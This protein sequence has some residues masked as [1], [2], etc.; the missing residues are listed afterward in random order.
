MHPTPRPLRAFTALAL[1]LLCA[2]DAAK[3]WAASPAQLLAGYSA[4]AGSAGV[5]ARGQQFFTSRHEKCIAKRLRDL[6]FA[7]LTWI[8][9]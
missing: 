1:T 9:I 6:F 4:Q 5:P 8:V 7:K 2:A 3:V